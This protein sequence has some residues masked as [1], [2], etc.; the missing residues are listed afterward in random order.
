M[1]YHPVS[2]AEELF[3]DKL[4]DIIRDYQVPISFISAALGFKKNTLY[5]IRKRTWIPETD[6][7]RK[8]LEALKMIE[9]YLNQYRGYETT[10]K[11]GFK[12][13]TFDPA[14]F[15]RWNFL[16]WSGAAVNAI[17]PWRL[18]E[19]LPDVPRPTTQPT[20]DELVQQKLLGILDQL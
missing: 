17:P 1:A 11:G 12:P 19:P 6:W 15:I 2:L 8:N 7:F 16:V 14:I 5:S 10:I 4:N 18:H 20:K 3:E 13:F 9:Q